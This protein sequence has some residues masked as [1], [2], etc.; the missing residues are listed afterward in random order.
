MRPID[1]DK[2]LT[3]SAKH[4]V[5]DY[6]FNLLRCLIE[7]TPT[8]S[9]EYFEDGGTWK[10]IFDRSAVVE[11]SKFI[12]EPELIELINQFGYVKVERIY[13]SKKQF[14]KEQYGKRS[15]DQRKA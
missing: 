14:K 11:T 7:D 5:R 9:E 2:L 8:L 4:M 13:K 15:K 12:A 1:A 10:Y 3:P 6:A